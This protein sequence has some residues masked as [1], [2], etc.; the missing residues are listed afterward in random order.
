MHKC[1]VFGVFSRK[2]CASVMP[3]CKQVCISHDSQLWRFSACMPEELTM[4][5]K[6]VVPAANKD[7][8]VVYQPE[9]AD[10]GTFPCH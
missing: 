4:K 2:H 6:D 8:I 5:K 3:D 7:E 1:I 10:G 9:G